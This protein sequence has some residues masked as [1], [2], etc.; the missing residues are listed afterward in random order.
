MAKSLNIVQSLATDRPAGTLGARAGPDWHAIAAFGVLAQCCNAYLAKGRHSLSGRRSDR[1]RTGL[2]GQQHHS[3]AIVARGVVLLDR[4]PSGE[5]A[6]A[7]EDKA[8]SGSG[9]PV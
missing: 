5:A 7:G 1:T 8:V 6:D 4:R 3:T 9:L 2:D